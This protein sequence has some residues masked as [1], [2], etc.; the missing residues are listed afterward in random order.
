ME[1]KLEKFVINRLITFKQRLD[2][3]RCD[4]WEVSEFVDKFYSD[5]LKVNWKVLEKNND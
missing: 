2:D 3:P 5:L 4:K 1:T